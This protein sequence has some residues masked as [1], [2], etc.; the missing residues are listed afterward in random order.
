MAE[1][2]DQII[3]DNIP[4]PVVEDTPIVEQEVTEDVDKD[5][6]VVQTLEEP[7]EQVSTISTKEPET[8]PVIKPKKV[9][10]KDTEKGI[11]SFVSQ[12]N[13][14]YSNLDFKVDDDDVL[15]TNVSTGEKYEY[16]FPK[17]TQGEDIPFNQLKIDRLNNFIELNSQS[18]SEAKYIYE[19]TG[20]TPRKT[21]NGETIYQYGGFLG[22]GT[23]SVNKPKMY[24]AINKTKKIARDLYVRN[25]PEFSI[26][27][28]KELA[29]MQIDFNAYTEQQLTNIKDKIYERVNDELIEETRVGIPKDIFYKIYDSNIFQQNL[30]S[31]INEIANEKIYDLAVKKYGTDEARPEFIAYKEKWLENQLDP[32]ARERL[33]TIN[34]IKELNKSLEEAEAR[35]TE[36]K[37]DVARIK[38]EI[39][40]EQTKIYTSTSTIGGVAPGTSLQITKSI[41]KDAFTPDGFWKMPEN[42]QDA[43]RYK[44][45]INSGFGDAAF[46][47]SLLSKAGIEGPMLEEKTDVDRMKDIYDQQLFL[48]QNIFDIGRE[49][50]LEFKMDIETATEAA[51]RG[52]EG[53]DVQMVL[54]KYKEENPEAYDEKTGKLKIPYN[55]FYKSSISVKDLEGFFDEAMGY[56]PAKDLL[57]YKA[58]KEEK[59]E[60]E[61]V[62]QGIHSLLYLNLDPAAVQKE[63]APVVFARNLIK[64]FATGDFYGE[65]D[66]EKASQA[67]NYFMGRDPRETL[68]NMKTAISDFNSKHPE[69]QLKLSPEQ[70]ENIKETISELTASGL[71]QFVPFL[72]EMA[73]IGTVT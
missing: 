39:A 27:D 22:I 33:S 31:S 64:A 7:K 13:N 61:G 29:G 51:A 49:K 28:A 70:E 41:N 46:I 53:G 55:D 18:D 50:S 25:N 21:K 44:K 43:D 37:R 52:L 26:Y 59:I 63:A 62:L 16:S 68:N 38:Q 15:V 12:M 60:T 9:K 42:E 66:E 69:N 71:G 40:N 19:E 58:W 57:P 65:M 3:Q 24:A 20:I 30:N 32:S 35:G 45:S 54:Q 10:I 4:Q 11:Q 14:N 23:E 5:L 47:A 72:F 48:S 34:K 6:Q 1:L 36:G 56:I 73:V 2:E 67:T 17:D 8:E